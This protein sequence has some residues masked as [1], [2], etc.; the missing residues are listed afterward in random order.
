[1]K[2]RGVLLLV[3][4]AL[5]VGV[6][7]FAPVGVTRAAPMATKTWDGG[8]GT[9]R[10]SDATNWNPD[11]VPG[12]TDD[13]ILDNSSVAGSYTVV[14]DNNISAAQTIKSVTI[15]YTG[16]SNTIILNIASSNVVAG[17]LTLNNAS[18][19]NELTIL[20]G[21][22]VNN[23]SGLTTGRAI[24]F[25]VPSKIFMMAGNAQ[26]LHNTSSAV[27]RASSSQN[28]WTFGGTSTFEYKT[29]STANFAITAAGITY[30]NLKLNAGGTSA[31]YN[32]S[33]TTSG[34]TINGDFVIGSNVT[35]NPGLSAGTTFKGNIINNGT[36]NTLAI[37]PI[38]FAG[39]TTISGSG[40]VAFNNGFTVNASSTLA[41]SQNGTLVASGKTATINGSFQINQSAFPGN[42]GTWTYGVGGTLIF[43]NSTGSYGVGNDDYWP[44]TNGPVNVT[45]QGAGGVTLNVARTVNGILA[46]TNGDLT[47]GAN[48]LTLGPNATTSGSGDVVGNV[49]RSAFVASTTYSFGNPNVTI[50][51]ASATTLP[52]DVTVTLG[53]TRPTG[54]TYSITRTYSIAQTGGVGFL[55]VL[56]L[57][58]LDSELNLA[59]GATEANLHLFKN[60]SGTWIDQGKSGNDATAN[61]VEQSGIDSFSEWTLSGNS[62][63][64]AITLTTFSGQTPTNQGWI[65]L[66][67]LVATGLL[68]GG[69]VL[70]RRATR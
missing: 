10:W 37:D 22:V 61:W 64:T 17:V 20:D 34:L 66:I 45:V 25:S 7:G 55:T 43:N 44:T 18:G 33:G 54:F 35:F 48:I 2:Q 13:V 1:M 51:F 14:I 36:W 30:Q 12:S 26:Y 38:T 57:H 5:V 19:N 46:L 67:L 3:S 15:G 68:I 6:V 52:T 23:Q 29:P 27:P 16:N 60:I 53:K 63:T 24:F 31:T 11:G 56:R 47:T 32:N 8:A 58:Y 62:T 65:M 21:G 41:T 39:N 9:N 70:R 40:A 50:N 59:N 4:L 28:V 69:W 49:K 42:S